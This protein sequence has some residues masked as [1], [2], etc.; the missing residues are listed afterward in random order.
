[1]TTQI[2]G[3]LRYIPWFVPFKG[4]DVEEAA[5][6]AVGRRG[7]ITTASKLAAWLTAREFGPI[8]PWQHPDYSR[9]NQVRI[10]MALVVKRL[11]ASG[12]LIREPKWPYHL[13]LGLVGTRG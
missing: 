8:R 7:G 6:R 5:F 11:I 9:R 2:A 13:S 10:E 1:M 12:A 3:E 4:I